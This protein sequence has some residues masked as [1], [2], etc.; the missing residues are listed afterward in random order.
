MKRIALTQ[1]KFAI[2]DDEDY[3]WLNQREWCEVRDHRTFYA[4]RTDRTSGKK[5]NIRMHR[6][7]ME[8]LS[9]FEIDHINGNG[10]DN[11]KVN[12]RICTSL[13]N[14]FNRRRRLDS[15]N[16]YKSIYWHK[17]KRKWQATISVN[18]KKHHLGY[19]EKEAEAAKAYD[20]A[21]REYFG[22]FANMN[23]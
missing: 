17:L 23:F 3:E 8:P 20:K 21:A 6:A 18:R 13:E 10:L 14:H 16:K 19:F 22:E 9:M 1:G 12:M 15:K 7:I 5:I 11:R 2:V 4:M